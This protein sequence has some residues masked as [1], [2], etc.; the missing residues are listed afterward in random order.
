LSQE[1]GID[2]SIIEMDF[3]RVREAPRKKE[4]ETS[5]KKP[6]P[7]SMTPELLL[8]IASVDSKK[9]FSKIRS[10]LSVDDFI[11]P[12]GK[13]AFITLEE[14]YRN[15]DWNRDVLLEKVGNETLRS[16]IIE[17]LASGE[18]S[19]NR[20]KM[21]HDAICGIRKRNFEK[22]QKDVERELRRLDFGKKENEAVIAELLERK[23]YIDG[24]LEKLRKTGNE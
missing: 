7:L 24:E 22:E 12:E 16:Y 2:K 10:R 13:D 21:I 3:Q 11:Q 5:E 17:K 4:L 18:L 6:N 15:D 9:D 1:F 8:I 23:M 14:N 19:E 20:E